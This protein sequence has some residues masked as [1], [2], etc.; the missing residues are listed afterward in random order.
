MKRFFF[1][2]RVALLVALLGSLTGC[3]KDANVESSWNEK[4]IRLTADRRCQVNV[5]V[6]VFDGKSEIKSSSRIILLKSN[7]PRTLKMSDFAIT[8]Y[9]E[10]AKFTEVNVSNPQPRI[11]NV[12]YIVLI[13]S[14]ICGFAETMDDASRGLEFDE[15]LT[16]I[17]KR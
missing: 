2:L 8:Y 7:S 17:E 11:D 6:L 5:D 15:L 4:E 1:V 12:I 10:D 9:G 13:L 14:V 3:A 16:L